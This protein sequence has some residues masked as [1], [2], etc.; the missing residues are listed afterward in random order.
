[1]SQPLDVNYMDLSSSTIKELY[2]E[3]ETIKNLKGLAL[4]LSEFFSISLDRIQ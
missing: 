2:R 4:S 1:M 3:S